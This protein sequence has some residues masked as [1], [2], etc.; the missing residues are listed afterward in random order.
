MS[1]SRVNFRKITLR[2]AYVMKKPC[3]HPFKRKQNIQ[4]TIYV[5]SFFF[6]LIL[7]LCQEFCVNFLDFL[8]KV[9]L[10]PLNKS[11]YR[12]LF[13][14]ARILQVPSASLHIQTAYDCKQTRGNWICCCQQKQ[15]LSFPIS[16]LKHLFQCLFCFFEAVMDSF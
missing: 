1:R 11:S 8:N 15:W 9:F 5:Y 7:R 6:I 2:E 4:Y 3:P 12:I 10:L 14:C 13:G 16:F